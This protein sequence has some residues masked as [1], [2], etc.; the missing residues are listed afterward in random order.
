[1]RR[2]ADGR[3]ETGRTREFTID[4]QLRTDFAKAG[5]LR[6]AQGV[7]RAYSLQNLQTSPD[8]QRTFG[9]SEPLQVMFVADLGPGAATASPEVEL[10]S[11]A[12]AVINQDAW[13]GV[14]GGVAREV[15]VFVALVF[16]LFNFG[17]STASRRLESQLGVGKR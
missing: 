11:V 7:L 16:F 13:F 15:Y 17:M 3:T 8:P 5:I 14:P 9:T 6:Q 2:G 12:K 4:E 10:V 1:M